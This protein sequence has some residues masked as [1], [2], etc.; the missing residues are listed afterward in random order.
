MIQSPSIVVLL[1]CDD[2]DDDA[3][4]RCLTNGHFNYCFNCCFIIQWLAIS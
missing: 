4:R 2:D 1:Q 3:T